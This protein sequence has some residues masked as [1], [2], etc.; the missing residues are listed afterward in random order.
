MASAY[1]ELVP[2]GEAGVGGISGGWSRGLGECRDFWGRVKQR[3]K[4]K[5]WQRKTKMKDVVEQLC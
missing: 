3:K 5:K 2:E 1:A 4:P